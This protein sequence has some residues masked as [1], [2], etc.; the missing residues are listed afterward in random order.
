MEYEI[1]ILTDDNTIKKICELFWKIKG[2]KDKYEFEKTVQE[3]AKENQLKSSQISQIAKVNSELWVNCTSCDIPF[4]VKNRT[5]W[6]KLVSGEFFF[7]SDCQNCKEKKNQ[8]DRGSAISKLYAQKNLELER[9]FKA[10]RWKLCDRESIEILIIIAE[11]FNLKMI[12]QELFRPIIANKDFGK[13]Q[14]RRINKLEELGLIWVEKQNPFEN[15]GKVKEFHILNRLR[16]VLHKKYREEFKNGEQI[17][18]SKQ[19]KII[20]DI[21]NSRPGF[22]E[23]EFNLSKNGYLTAFKNYKIELNLDKKKNQFKINIKEK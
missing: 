18:D 23:G 6:K 10:K 3:I 2:F 13:L 8:I 20:S 22:I 14:W 19:L 4:L 5:E 21:N 12:N 9:A 17:L 15:T 7:Q 1:K 16:E 11:G